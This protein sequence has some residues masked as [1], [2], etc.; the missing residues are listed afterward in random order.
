MV[1]KSR[2]WRNLCVSTFSGLWKSRRPTTNKNSCRSVFVFYYNDPDPMGPKS[3]LRSWPTPVLLNSVPSPLRVK[4]LLR[5]RGYRWQRL[6][7]G[8]R[9]VCTRCDTRLYPA[10]TE[11]KSAGESVS[12]VDNQR[13]SSS[14]WRD[15]KSL[16]ANKDSW[17]TH[18]NLND[19]LILRD[20]VYLV[21]SLVLQVTKCKYQVTWW[22]Y[23][24]SLRIS[25][26]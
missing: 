2:K 17:M 3:T 21:A 14:A 24:Q 18:A 16:S 7:E 22:M 26:K 11:T 15:N 9:S 12:F 10:V 19:C 20:S 6:L 8:D 4:S 25:E 5:L 13:S 23:K 1:N